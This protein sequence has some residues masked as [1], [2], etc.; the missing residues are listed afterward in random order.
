M[1]KWTK[2]VVLGYD[3]SKEGRYALQWAVD[4]AQRRGVP[5]V[6]VYASDKEPTSVWMGRAAVLEMYQRRA[7]QIA[8]EGAERARAMAPIQVE[9]IGLSGGAAAG[10]VERSKDASLMVLGHR[11]RGALRETVVGSVALQVTTHAACPVAVVRSA[12]A[13]LPSM[14]HP[15]VVGVDGSERG[16]SALNEAALLA[17][18]TGSFLRIVTAW[19]APDEDLWSVKSK[20]RPAKAKGDSKAGADAEDVLSA[21]QRIRTELASDRPD[22]D[23]YDVL[24][25]D[26]EQSAAN[27]ARAAT[28]HVHASYPDLKVEQVVQ[29]G[30]AASVILAA[31]AGAS[32]IVVGSRGYSALQSLLLG[33]V[34]RK[35]INRANCAVY[36]IR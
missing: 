13:P 4:V 15:V 14:E 35:I 27:A 7:L 10:L 12:P 11:T 3:T 30:S 5:L 6:V 17:A 26:V 25:D 32:V 20:N 1:T 18:D 21:Y 2:P 19:R 36:V 9:A 29:K 23:P 16:K 28:E 8:E 24:K 34:S 33:S 31:A 22:A